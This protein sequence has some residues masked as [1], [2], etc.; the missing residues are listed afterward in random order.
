M[1][2]HPVVFTAAAALLAIVGSGTWADGGAAARQGPV[3]T[4]RAGVDLIPVDVQVVGPDGQPLTTLAPDQFEVTIDGR[5]R[6]VVSLSVVDYRGAADRPAVT[7]SVASGDGPVSQPERAAR[8]FILAVDAS[9]FDEATARPVLRAAARFIDQLSADDE[10]GLFTYPIGPKVDPTTDHAAVSRALNGI[11]ARRETPAFSQ[12]GLSPSDV[13]ELSSWV[14]DRPTAQAAR[15]VEQLCGGDGQCETL[16]KAEELGEVLF[17]EGLLQANL[18]TLRQLMAELAR[19]PIRKTVVLVSGGMV[20]A[21][22]P[23]LRPD[24]QGLAI[25]VGKAAAQANASVYSLFLDQ[26][27]RRSMA[28]ETRRARN[29]VID[30]TRDRDLQGRWLDQFSGT[31]GGTMTSVLVDDGTRAFERILA[32]TSAYYLLGV[33]PQPEDR[34]G[35]AHELRVRVR[36][37]QVNVRGRSFV[38]LPRPG[39]SVAS[40]AR[41]APPAGGAVPPAAVAGA[42]VTPEL[43]ALAAAFDRSDRSALNEAIS[44]RDGVTL[45]RTFRGSQSP[46]SNAPRYTAAFALDIALAGLRTTS[47]YTREQ[48]LQIL[49]EYTVRVRQPDLDDPF[50]CAWLQAAAAGLSGL[51]SPQTA[52]GFV[53]RAAARCPGDHRTQLSAA[54]VR[55]QLFVRATSAAATATSVHE[56]G[57]RVLADYDALAAD[58][59][60]GPEARVRAAWLAYRLDDANAGLTRLASHPGGTSDPLLIYAGF[61]VR[62]QLL[63]LAGRTDEAIDAARAALAAWPEAQSGRVVLLTL[64][65]HRGDV[66]EAASVAEATQTAA[67]ALDPWWVF[68]LGDYRAYLDRLAHL[69]EVAR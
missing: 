9:S 26:A 18:V 20:T 46:W 62:A 32:E 56:D 54:I 51:Q 8:V 55:D 25:D 66:A 31:A 1:R 49:A 23:G 19:V 59:V 47:S 6:R 15:L 39:T 65:V 34:D 4:F 68:S 14:D 22:G 10:V 17:Y 48:A 42:P 53:E 40:G 5:R 60:V 50:E 12:F 16:L 33:E 52:A 30:Y 58:P 7:P 35:R 67:P 61:L 45:L 29:T 2:T 13:V 64:L 3:P 57:Q 43:Q 11:V 28:A 21:D 44:G 63:R 37:K 69:R 41:P 36:E 27:S 38:V 24:G